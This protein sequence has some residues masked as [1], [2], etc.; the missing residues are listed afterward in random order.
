MSRMEMTR[1]MIVMMMS[2]LASCELTYFDDAWN[3]T[4]GNIPL[5]THIRGAIDK[6]EKEISKTNVSRPCIYE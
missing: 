6:T 3:N 2:T 4:L 5:R 1:R